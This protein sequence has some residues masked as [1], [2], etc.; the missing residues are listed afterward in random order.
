MDEQQR[1]TIELV[2]D[3]AARQA[4]SERLPDEIRRLVTDVEG[5]P[6]VAEARAAWEAAENQQAALT[7]AQRGLNDEAIRLSGQIT[8]AADQLRDGLIER[9]SR[10]P[11]PETGTETLTERLTKL[12][13]QHSALMSA[14]SFVVAHGQPR[15][16]ILE[17]EARGAYLLARSQGIQT[18]AGA[19]L[20]STINAL[21]GVVAD[22]GGLRI[23]PASTLSGQILRHA[24]EIALEAD[25]HKATAEELRSKYDEFCQ[26]Q[27]ARG[28]R[29]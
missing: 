26:R 6:A 3:P 19:R 9:F 8:L 17:H 23:D 1:Q 7:R 15:A 20:A 29:F 10:Q 11:A 4:L 28:F 18:A 24:Q 16:T 5:T 22:E 27:A 12:R 25:R 21:R 13:A 2:P 14:L